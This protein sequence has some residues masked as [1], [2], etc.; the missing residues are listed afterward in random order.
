LLRAGVSAYQISLD[1]PKR[2]HDRT[3]VQK[4]GS[5]S[6]DLILDNLTAIKRSSL[7]VKVELRL[8]I[9]AENKDALPA[10][11]DDLADL[12]LADSRFCLE[13]FPIADL[14]GPR[15]GQFEV[16]SHTEATRIA[17]QIR[18]R[19]PRRG[20][21]LSDAGERYVCY[22]AKG[23]AFVIRSDGTLAKCTTA[24]GN[25]QNKVGS[26]LPDGTLS[27]DAQMLR[28]WLH[29]WESKNW[30]DLGCPLMSLPS[31]KEYATG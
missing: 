21:T 31:G 13:P 5:A 12:L 24:F 25:P 8:H 9:T 29:G 18:E 20:Q 7:D 26:I 27:L 19:A 30:G 3:R 4:R 16:L 1:G 28:P 6:F 15:S 17:R 14:G 23:N 10:F 2:Y 22:A 11:V